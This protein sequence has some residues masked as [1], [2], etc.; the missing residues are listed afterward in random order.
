MADNPRGQFVWY[1]LATSDTDAA[2]GFYTDLIGW[3][4]QEWE[5]GPQ[6]YTLWTNNDAPLGGVMVLPE[7]AKKAGAPPHWMAYIDTPD[8]DAAVAQVGELGGVVHHPVTD[9]PGAGKFAVLADPQGAVFSVYASEQEPGEQKVPQPGDISWHELGTTDYEAAFEF[10]STVFG[11]QKT[12]E[13]DMGEGNI[14]MMYGVGGP[15]LGGIYTKPTDVPGPPAAW[16]YYITVDDVTAG[17]EKVKA[18]GGQVL[19]GPMEVP[20]GSGDMVAQCMDPQGAAFA[21][22][23]TAAGG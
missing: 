2:I 1:D 19:N 20:G 8:I 9:I 13:M 21:I 22:H 14:Y 6:P 7:D 17:A 15:P 3:G 23:S 5:G 10:Y 16:L 12:D 11:W 18:L 4:T